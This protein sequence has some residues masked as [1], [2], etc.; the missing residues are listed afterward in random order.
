MYSASI[1]TCSPLFRANGAH[2]S[3]PIGS[4]TS[5]LRARDAAGWIYAI[6]PVNSFLHHLRV[7]HRVGM[8]VAKTSLVRDLFPTAR[9]PNTIY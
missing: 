2:S 5:F 7:F 4:L 9:Q 1:T 3:V 6:H 8:V